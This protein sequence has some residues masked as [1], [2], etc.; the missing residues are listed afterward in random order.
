M[1][2]LPVP[3]GKPTYFEG[4]IRKVNPNAFGFFLCEITTPDYLK[5]PIIQ[6]HSDTKG[7]IRTVAGLGKFKAVIFSNE[8]DNAIKL[9]YNFKILKGYTFNKE[10][11]FD[12]FVTDLYDLRLSY[13]KSHPLNFIAKI[14]LNSLYGSSEA[15][16]VYF[17]QRNYSI[18]C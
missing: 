9:G 16:N 4:D 17:I 12:K 5:H 1:S 13:P 8:I 18:R 7:G 2:H 10:I 14:L 11:V 15:R 3:V 6:I